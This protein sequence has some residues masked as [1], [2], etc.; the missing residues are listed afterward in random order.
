MKAEQQCLAGEGWMRSR[1]PGGGEHNNE[2]T[3]IT[4]RGVR[5]CCAAQRSPAVKC[6]QIILRS[7]QAVRIPRP[8]SDRCRSF[9]GYSQKTPARSL[10]WRLTG[11]CATL[12][13]HPGKE[14]VMRTAMQWSKGCRFELRQSYSFNRNRFLLTLWSET[15]WGQVLFIS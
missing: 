1:L 8:S 14:T 6:T 15:K 3:K 5:Y 13:P 12:L 4:M 9:N 7:V 10:F 11:G 2:S